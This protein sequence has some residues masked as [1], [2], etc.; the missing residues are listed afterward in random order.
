MYHAVHN[1][2]YCVFEQT[3]K[4]RKADKRGQEEGKKTVPSMRLLTEKHQQDAKADTL[5]TVC[6]HNLIWVT[7]HSSSQQ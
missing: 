6:H 5:M 1:P 2:R 3:N 7:S 4:C